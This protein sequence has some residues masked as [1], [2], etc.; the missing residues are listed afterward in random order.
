[1]RAT[2]IQD[3]QIVRALKLPTRMHFRAC[4]TTASPEKKELRT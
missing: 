3:A 4:A 2:F 1:M